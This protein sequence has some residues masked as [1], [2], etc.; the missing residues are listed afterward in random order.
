M[1]RFFFLFSI[2]LATC[3]YLFFVYILWTRIIEI[4]IYIYIYVCMY[5]FILVL[6]LRF[7][8]HDI[9]VNIEFC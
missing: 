9:K 3:L 5:I 4:T 8:F 2:Y 1:L 7:L 6:I